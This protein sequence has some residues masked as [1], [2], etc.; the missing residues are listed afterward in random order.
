MH[1]H[2]AEAVSDYLPDI[3]MDPRVHRWFPFNC[4][5]LSQSELRVDADADANAAAPQRKA[6]G[7]T[8]RWSENLLPARRKVVGVVG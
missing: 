4:L 7:P 3:G 6:R 5:S 2:A 1:G 8:T